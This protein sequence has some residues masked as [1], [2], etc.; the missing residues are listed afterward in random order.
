MT[1]F[2]HLIVWQKA[3]ALA[4]QVYRTTGTFPADERFGLTSQMR[5]AAVSVPSNVAEGSGRSSDADFA[6]FID[7]ALGSSTEL[8]YQLL[9][10]RDLGFIHNDRYQE[11]D[12]LLAEVKRLLVGFRS[13][14]RLPAQRSAANS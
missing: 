6:R 14:L 8:E 2:Q 7:I 13:R 1:A 3:H 10:A 9:L 11:L 12:E 4:L 5:R